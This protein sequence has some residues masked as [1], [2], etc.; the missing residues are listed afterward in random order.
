VAAAG[1]S[2][3]EG[4]C[5]AKLARRVAFY[6]TDAMGV[7]HHANY[8]RFFED[9]RIV[10]MDTWDEPYRAWVARDLHFA[11]TQVEL[12]CVR[13]AAFDDVLEVTTWLEWVRGASLRM[14]YR[15]RR[16]EDVIVTGATEHACVD[17]A[18]RVRRLPADARERFSKHSL[19]MEEKP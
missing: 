6:E 19:R 5:V 12:R 8:L 11:V 7:V 3:P 18:G 14:A 13:S 16:G 9:A 10:W 17:G 15:I 4:A 1:E 2:I